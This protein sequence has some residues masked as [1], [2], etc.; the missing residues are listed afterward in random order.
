MSARDMVVVA[1]A[2]AVIPASSLVGISRVRELERNNLERP[3]QPITT[4]HLIHAG[5]YVRTITIPAN[6]LLTGA[7][8][9]R[10]TVLHFD[11]DA[12][13]TV[14]DDVMRLTGRHVIP[15]S[16]GR[17]QAYLT[18]KDTTLSMSFATS[19]K[20]IEEAEAEFTDEADQLFSR[21]GENVINITG[22]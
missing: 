9:K 20:T 4:H 3:Q 22:E 10:S 19:A 5:L 15:A 2:G 14:G 21:H 12:T 18:H 11:G 1:G 6:T 16:A 13:V 8:I 7:L 17:K